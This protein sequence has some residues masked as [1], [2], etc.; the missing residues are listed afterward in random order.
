V[1]IVSRGFVDQS[2]LQAAIQ[3]AQRALAPDVIRIMHSFAVDWQGEQSL[4]FRVLL[5][6]RASAP[7]KLRETTQKVVT[8]IL[9]EIKTNELGLQTYFNFRSKSE[10]NAL[11]EPAWEA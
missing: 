8:K 11:R 6:D 7:A 1:S 3:R 10:Q 2:K 9:A 4:F 5:S